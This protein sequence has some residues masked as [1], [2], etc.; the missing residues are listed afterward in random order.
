M[1]IA[2]LALWLTAVLSLPLVAFAVQGDQ[3][4]RSAGVL[5]LTLG[6]AIRLALRNNRSLHRARLQRATDRFSL[7]V[8]GDRYRPKA[9][10]AVSTSADNRRPGTVE[11]SAGP[12]LRIPGGGEVRLMYSEPLARGS[13]DVGTWTLGLSQPLLKGFGSG[14]DAA[15]LHIARLRE[16]MS[17]LS[18]RDAIADVVALVI[19]A[20]RGVLRA[21]RSTAIS[22][23]S[24]ARARAQLEINRSLIR[25]GRMAARE[26][27][28]SEAE[29]AKRELA[30]VDSDNSLNSANAALLSVLDIDGAP[31]IVV[32]GKPLT[33]EEAVRADLEK[34]I[35]TAFANRTDYKSASIAREIASIEFRL[36]ASDTLW[37]L[38]LT[39]QVSRGGDDGRDRDYGVA[40]GLTIPFGDR[41]PELKVVSARN[42]VRDADIALLEFR[43]SIRIEVGQAAH[44]V[45]VGL[46]RIELAHTIREL[47][48]E[49]L[50]VERS[51]L[52][53]GLASAY[54]L[55]L[56]EG[57]LVS[58]QNS[59]LD[60]IISYL[61]AV[62]S[63][64]RTLGTT[65]RTWAIDAE[66]GLEWA[67]NGGD[68]R[69]LRS[70][71]TASAPALRGTPSTASR[72]A[73]EAPVPPF[74]VRRVGSTS[75]AGLSSRVGSSLLLRLVDFES[76]WRVARPAGSEDIPA[77]DAALVRIVDD[78]TARESMPPTAL[79]IRGA[80][81]AVRVPAE[82][83]AMPE[84]PSFERR[85]EMLRIRS[86]RS[87]VASAEQQ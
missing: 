15:P 23:D 43:Q 41:L 22:R 82:H 62:A 31:R 58:A 11:I 48:E 67:P 45:E 46:R 8:A 6:E 65:L 9:N 29:I 60:A 21:K 70:D 73:I 44:E 37:D 59:E 32:A 27:V 64:D 34:S 76:A 63:L 86:V 55:T 53:Q 85:V 39:A 17:L 33:V 40:L 71:T 77:R 4:P 28:Q 87:G 7:D 42:A 79:G 20:Y 25:A 30:L 26:I 50:E 38:T 75:L 35:N 54:R 16:Q 68:G 72:P 51:K 14:I 69:E 83:R 84:F 47:A 81:G 13:E 57:D 49:R 74:A 19:D 2:I 56:V 61:D 52:V 5:E 12:S 3:D 10:V 78:G 80:G 1:R 24:L 66:A 36:A 18:F